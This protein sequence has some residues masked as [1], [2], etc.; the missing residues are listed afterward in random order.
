[1]SERRA[2][3]LEAVPIRL[4]FGEINGY[5]LLVRVVNGPEALIDK[6][7]SV[8]LTAKQLTAIEEFET[9]ET[10]TGPVGSIELE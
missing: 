2:I 3:P 8:K 5:S 6:R 10:S 7:I 4:R 9:T 1:M